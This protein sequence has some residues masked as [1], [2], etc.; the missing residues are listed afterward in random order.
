MAHNGSHNAKAWANLGTT[1]EKSN[2]KNVNH[3]TQG[4]RKSNNSSTSNTQADEKDEYYT[5]P[6]IYKQLSRKQKKLWNA[7]WKNEAKKNLK[8]PNKLPQQ[9]GNRNDNNTSTNT[10]NN[11][12]ATSDYYND[13]STTEDEHNF[14]PRVVN[15]LKANVA[16]VRTYGGSR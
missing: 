6:E 14:M 16:M 1:E 11:N 5:N 8:T 15:N 7:M 2:N 3:K 12:L 10:S 13:K 9:Y 4:N